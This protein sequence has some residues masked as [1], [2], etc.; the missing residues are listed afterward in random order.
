MIPTNN[1]PTANDLLM[2]LSERELSDMTNPANR[3]N[4]AP[5]DIQNDKINNAL[6]LAD[7]V[8]CSK[9]IGCQPTGKVALIKM[10]KPVTLMIARYF[11]DREKSRPS[12]VDQYNE[13]LRLMKDACC[14][15]CGGE[16]TAEEAE[17]IGWTT[18]TAKAYVYSE[19]G[20]LDRSQTAG[21]QKGGLFATNR[22]TFRNS[23]RRSYSSRRNTMR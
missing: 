16:L 22:T 1:K 15:E 18:S 13:A 7:S 14:S 4:C 9:Y 10:R 21:Y 20:T 8:W 19:D 2:W 5:E 6:E 3:N 23:A 17:L 11:L 12:V